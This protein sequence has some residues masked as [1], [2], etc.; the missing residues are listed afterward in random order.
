MLSMMVRSQKTIHTMLM[1]FNY[2]RKVWK[3]G[4][5]NAVWEN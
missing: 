4:Y 1:F 2:Q 5:Y 3:E